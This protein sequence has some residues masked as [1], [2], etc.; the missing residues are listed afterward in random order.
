MKT[1]LSKILLASTILLLAASGAMAQNSIAV[2]NAAAM[3]PDNG[4]TACG[5]GNCGMEIIFPGGSTNAARVQDD[6]PAD[7]AIY[8]AVF[9]YDPSNIADNPSAAGYIHIFQRTTETG[10]F[11]APY[12]LILLQKSNLKRLFIRSLTNPS[13][14][15]FSNR[16]NLT[17]ANEFEVT[18]TQSPTPGVAGGNVKIEVLTGPQAGQCVETKDTSP[19][20]NNSQL[21]VDNVLAGAVGN[22]SASVTGSAYFDE[23]SSFRTLAPFG[24]DC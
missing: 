24:P 9:W 20:L 10:T 7:E 4:G 15:R 17:G 2:N 13:V 12:Q 1:K 14:V 11:R 23:F 18:F 16:I 8:R 5:G 6:T 21:D 3:G 19:G 22:I